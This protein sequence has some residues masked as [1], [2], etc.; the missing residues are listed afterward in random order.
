MVFF[1][2]DTGTT[3]SYTYCHTLSLHDA[4]PI[5]ATAQST[6]V[7][8]MASLYAKRATGRGYTTQTS[9]LGMAA[10]TQGERL[11]GPDGELTDTYH[12]TSDQTGFS[13]WHRIYEC[14]DGDRKS[15][16]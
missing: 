4:L 12:L 6:R 3:E 14:A 5:F 8:L 9:L 13:P 1:L 2:N 10:F 11:I 7:E 15:V 16:V